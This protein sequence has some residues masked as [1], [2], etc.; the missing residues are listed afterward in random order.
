MNIEQIRAEWLPAN[1][2]D[3][4]ILRDQLKT[5]RQSDG[6]VVVSCNEKLGDDTVWF[7]FQLYWLQ[8]I[9]LTHPL[10]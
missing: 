1:S 9:G 3:A 7:V 8:A 10:K 5:V 6:T 2:F 4:Q